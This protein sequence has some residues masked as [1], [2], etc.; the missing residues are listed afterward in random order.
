MEVIISSQQHYRI[1]FGEYLWN[2]Q[3]LQIIGSFYSEA[4]SSQGRRD[5]EKKRNQFWSLGAAR[6]L[7]IDQQ[8]ESTYSAVY[9]VISEGGLQAA[10]LD[11]GHGSE[12]FRIY[13]AKI[14]AILFRFLRVVRKSWRQ[15]QSRSDKEELFYSSRGVKCV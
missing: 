13:T 3:S 9:D 11:E 4:L 1:V 5:G 6:S 8:I 10:I 2:F 15:L 12:I 7:S 14:Q